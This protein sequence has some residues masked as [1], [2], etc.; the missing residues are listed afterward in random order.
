VAVLVVAGGQESP[1]QSRIELGDRHGASGKK[2]ARAAVEA[3][4][5]GRALEVEYQDGD[6]AG[7]YEVEVRRPTAR[8]SR[9]I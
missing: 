7:V 5:G 1:T 8:M 2:A 9:F 4:G 6:S 3:A